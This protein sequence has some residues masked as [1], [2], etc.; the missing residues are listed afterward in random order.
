M[1]AGA[2]YNYL[3]VNG[4]RRLTEREMLRLQGFPES[5]LLD[6]GY[7]T[8]RR[9]TGN[10]LPIPVAESVIGAVVKSLEVGFDK[11]VKRKCTK[12]SRLSDNV[13]YA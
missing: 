8:A 2:S 7:T 3:L 4:E 6:C 1:R 11:G 10:S 13:I 9:L 12:A 5:F